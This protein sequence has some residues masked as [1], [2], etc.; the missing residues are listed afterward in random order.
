MAAARLMLDG[1]IGC[2]GARSTGPGWYGRLCA[3]SLSCTVVDPVAANRGKVGGCAGWIDSC[4]VVDQVATNRG[5][6]GGC[7]GWIDHR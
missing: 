2:W 3:G 6:V 4:T 5:K 1:G 7:A